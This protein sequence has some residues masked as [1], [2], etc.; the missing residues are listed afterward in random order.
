MARISGIDI[1]R[2]KQTEIALTYIFGVGR[3]IVVDRTA[4]VRV[5][6]GHAR[7]APLA[8]PGQCLA[9]TVGDGLPQGVGV[10]HVTQIRY[11]GREG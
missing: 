5:Q 2:D 3:T 6:R 4:D 10:D 1:P 7:P 11:C 8:I 9:N